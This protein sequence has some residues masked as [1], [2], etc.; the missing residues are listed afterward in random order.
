MREIVETAR[1]ELATAKGCRARR[2]EDQ[3]REAIRQN[4]F[5]ARDQC[6]ICVGR[7]CTTTNFLRS[8]SQ[9]RVNSAKDFPHLAP[10]DPIH[11]LWPHLGRQEI[12]GIEV[13]IRD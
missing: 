4:L 11:Q 5:P 12:G 6:D 8:F 2:F 13:W 1:S 10:P 3:N 7:Q 9:S